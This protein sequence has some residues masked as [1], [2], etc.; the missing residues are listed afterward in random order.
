MLA[1]DL[2]TNGA[3]RRLA[4]R[5]CH[6]PDGGAAALGGALASNMGLTSLDLAGNCISWEG[7]R[8]LAQG[9]LQ[10]VLGFRAQDRALPPRAP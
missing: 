8:S 10:V 6:L 5:D 2:S 9:D 7:A 1:K 4:L 3:L